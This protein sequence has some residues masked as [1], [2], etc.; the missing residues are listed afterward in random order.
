M[1]NGVDAAVALAGLGLSVA[2]FDW[3]SGILAEPS[4]DIETVRTLFS[5]RKKELVGYCV[6]VS[7]FY[8]LLTDCLQALRQRILNH[9]DL[10]GL[11][12]LVGYSPEFLPS[13]KGPGIGLFALQPGDTIPYIELIH[14]EPGAGSVVLHPVWK[15]EGQPSG[16]PHGGH[17][18]VPM[19]LLRALVYKPEI[20]AWLN[21]PSGAWMLLN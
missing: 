10:S 16:A 14:Q 3:E 4:R 8:V 11:C 7:P 5:G 19:Q 1:V 15:T 2:P 12:R 13:G 21:C 17:L 9:L 6:G 18:P 20:A